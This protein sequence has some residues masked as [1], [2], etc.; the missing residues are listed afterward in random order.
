MKINNTANLIN[1]L[2]PQ[3]YDA[4]LRWYKQSCILISSIS[5]ILFGISAYHYWH[6]H[7]LQQEAP[8]LLLEH[9]SITEPTM[10]VMQKELQRL[11]KHEEEIE[12]FMQKKSELLSQLTTLI[13][14]MPPTICLTT[15]NFESGVFTELSGQAC[16]L[17]TVTEFLQAVRSLPH[18]HSMHV[19]KIQPVSS[20]LDKK[21]YIQFTLQC[22]RI[23]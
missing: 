5:C 9:T 6:L 14:L 20:A 23:S 17:K 3:K 1:P 10:Q 2:S 7:T 15:C 21:E 16:A 13:A 11:E 18:L 8:H 12:T 4:Y 19:T 22:T